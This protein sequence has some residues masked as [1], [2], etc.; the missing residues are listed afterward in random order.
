MADVPLSVNRS[1]IDIVGAQE[2]RVVV[3]PGAEC[4]RRFLGRREPD[5]FDAFDLER[6]NDVFMAL[7][8]RFV[9]SVLWN[10]S[11]LR[12]EGGVRKIRS[13]R[14]PPLLCVI[15]DQARDIVPFSCPRPPRKESSTRKQNAH[16]RAASDSTRR[17]AARAVPN[18]REEVVMHEHRDRLERSRR[19][20][21]RSSPSVLESVFPAG[22][23]SEGSFPRLRMAR[24]RPE[25]LAIA[26]PG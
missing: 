3:A 17:H 10:E 14:S 6:F 7:V 12:R 26:P 21:S 25:G 13:S 11:P 5:R 16:H 8:V 22:S 1:I 23:V 15:I 2:E 19:G 4:A 24:T 20:G 18:R 9:P